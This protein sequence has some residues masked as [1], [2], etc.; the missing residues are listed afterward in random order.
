MD[1]RTAIKQKRTAIAKAQGEL[2]ALEKAAQVLGIGLRGRAAR[3]A[4]PAKKRGRRKLTKAQRA[5]ISKRM[6]KSWAARKKA[7]KA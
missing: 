5:A 2:A 1:I 7:K 4:A 6:K 3:K